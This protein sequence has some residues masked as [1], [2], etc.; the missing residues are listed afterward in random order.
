MRRRSRRII[1]MT[2]K[3]ALTAWGGIDRLDTLDTDRIR[4]FIDAYAGIAHH[5]RGLQ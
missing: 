1:A 3:I 5:P 4:G 2:P